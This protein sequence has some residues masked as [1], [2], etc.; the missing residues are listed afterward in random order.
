MCAHIRLTFTWGLFNIPISSEVWG[1]LNEHKASTLS[2][3]T[4]SQFLHSGGRS[5]VFKSR[6]LWWIPAAFWICFW[7]KKSVKNFN[8]SLPSFECI[9]PWICLSVATISSWPA[10]RYKIPLYAVLNSKWRNRRL[11]SSEVLEKCHQ[12]WM[13]ARG[14]Y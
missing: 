3:L 8:F 7:S 10:T 6:I 13:S 14:L 12:N 5:R 11:A 2:S 4:S 1:P 9:F